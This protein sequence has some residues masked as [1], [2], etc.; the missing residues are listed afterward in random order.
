M[1]NVRDTKRRYGWWWG[2]ARELSS[3]DEDIVFSYFS[4]KALRLV[5]VINI[6]LFCYLHLYKQIIDCST[7]G[8]IRSCF[9]I[10]SWERVR[11]NPEKGIPSRENPDT[12]LVINYTCMQM[13]K[14]TYFLLVRILVVIMTVK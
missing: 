1:G 2:R 8:G 4:N 11:D 14:H 5:L 13:Q 12:G 6:S 9:P 10:N 7:G 3:S